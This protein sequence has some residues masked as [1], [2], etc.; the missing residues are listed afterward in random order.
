MPASTTTLRVVARGVA[1]R[2]RPAR[3]VASPWRRRP[4]S[5]GWRGFTKHGKPISA[6][7]AGR[8]ASVV[9]A[10][11]VDH[12]PPA[13]RHAGIAEDRLHHRLVHADR[14]REHARADVRD[15]GQLEQSLDRAVFAVVPWRTGKTTSSGI[16]APPP[17]GTSA[18]RVGS[19]AVVTS[20]AVIGDRL[21]RCA[22]PRRAGAGCR[23]RCASGRPC[24]W[25]SARP[26][27]VRDRARRSR[28]RRSEARSRALP[29]V[30]R[31]GRRLASA[32]SWSRCYIDAPEKTSTMTS[33]MWRGSIF[34]RRRTPPGC[35]PDP[36]RCRSSPR[37]APRTTGSIM[38]DA[39]GRPASAAASRPRSRDCDREAEVLQRR[40]RTGV[41]AR[42]LEEHQHEVG[43]LGTFARASTTRG[44]APSCRSWTTC[45]RR[46]GWLIERDGAAPSSPRRRR[47]RC[48]SDGLHGSFSATRVG[49][50]LRRAPVA[51][52]HLAA[53]RRRVPAAAERCGE[54]RQIDVAV[55]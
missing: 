47:R 24:R 16:G 45:R 1:R 15:V 28:W 36:G 32:A 3:R 40:R 35:R 9:S 37:S 26:R 52:G 14:R 41:L 25:R 18:R 29:I 55:G 2:R 4:T 50:Q 51:V 20:I 49:D 21:Q 7:D 22:A 12:D 31:T 39:L 34:F 33:A 44:R 13:H 8:D 38:Q 19:G 6:A 48:V 10:A 5:P 53:G 11:G 30:H 54:L 17:S 43:L 23:C 46:R 42:H 27:S